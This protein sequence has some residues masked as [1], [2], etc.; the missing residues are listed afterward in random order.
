M[1]IGKR[2]NSGQL[3]RVGHKTVCRFFVHS[4]T[5]RKFPRNCSERGR[6]RNVCNSIRICSWRFRPHAFGK[7]LGGRHK[8]AAGELFALRVSYP[9]RM[10]AALRRLSERPLSRVIFDSD[11]LFPRRIDSAL[12]RLW[13]WYFSTK[14][15]KACPQTPQRA[16]RDF[17]WAHRRTKKQ[18]THFMQR[19]T[20]LIE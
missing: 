2:I 14:N 8:K 3:Y 9:Q 20:H 15:R 11:P 1:K 13:N 16:S 4:E 19:A 18:G 17:N 6:T 10:R 12:H 7:T 5:V